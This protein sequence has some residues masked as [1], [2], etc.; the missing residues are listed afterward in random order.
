MPTVPCGGSKRSGGIFVY[1]PRHTLCGCCILGKQHI[2]IKYPQKAQVNLSYDAMIM[3]T[4][5]Q[6]TFWKVETPKILTVPHSNLTNGQNS[7]RNATWSHSL[8]LRLYS[9]ACILLQN[10]FYSCSQLKCSA[11]DVFMC[12]GENQ[13]IYAP[14]EVHSLN[15]LLA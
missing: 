14:V 7:Q 4:M 8:P 3:K 9:S 5:N 11:R 15:K 2:P 10:L 1:K 12:E 6:Y 13:G